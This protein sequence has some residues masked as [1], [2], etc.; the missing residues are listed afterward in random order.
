MNTSKK[1][2]C[3]M[4]Y[5]KYK[6]GDNFLINRLKIMFQFIVI[7]VLLTS[8]NNS[9]GKI[10]TYRQITDNDI[11]D[12]SVSIDNGQ[13]AWRG[14]GENGK[15]AIFFMDLNEGVKENLTA[16]K[17]YGY[18]G[19][20]QISNGQ[21]TWRRYDGDNNK[22]SILLWDGQD[23]HIVSEYDCGDFPYQGYPP[24]YG[25][26]EP[27]L[28]NGQIAYAAWDGNDYEIFY[29]NGTEIIQITDNLTNDYEAQLWNGTISYTGYKDESAP[30]DIFYWDG[31]EIQNISDKAG[32][33]EDSHLRESKIVH[34]AYGLS[35]EYGTDIYIWDGSQDRC[36][37]PVIGY[38]YE[39][40]IF[41]SLICWTG[42][43]YGK[44][45]G[46]CVGWVWD[47][48]KLHN[49]ME[50][51]Y[52]VSFPR[53][54]GSM[55]AF[56]AHDGND[57][58][59]F[60]AEY[61]T[62]TYKPVTPAG[63]TLNILLENELAYVANGE[64]DLK[65]V[66][67]SDEGNPV[68]V[69]GLYIPDA[70]SGFEVQKRG[71]Y[72][73]LANRCGGVKIIDV[74]DGTNPILVSTVETPDMATHITL[75]GNYLYIG[76]RLG[77]LRILD[78]TIPE[79]VNEVGNLDL[80]GTTYGIA[81]KDNFAYV[82]NDYDG[83]Q[84]VDISDP[85]SPG[86]V[87][88]YDLSGITVWDIKIHDDYA[89]L[90][91]PGYG[92]KVLDISD[93]YDLREIGEC[94]LPDGSRPDHFLPPLDISFVDHYAFV[95]HG[96]DGALVLDISNP[97]YPRIVERIDT[98]GYAWGMSIRG[99]YL[100]VADGSE[101]FQIINISDYMQ[102]LYEDAEDGR[103][104]G[105]DIYD[106]SPDGAQVTN[107]F[108]ED[109][110][111]RVIHLNGSGHLNGYRLRSDDGSEWHN[112]SQ[113]VIEWSMKYSEFFTVY[114]DIETTA[115]QR[116]MVYKPVDFDDLGDGGYV[117]HGLGSDTIDGQWHTFVHD[118]Q[119]DIEEA[120]PGVTIL[121][122]NGF[123]IRGSG[124]VDDIG[125]MDTMLINQD[126]DS[127]G[128]TDFNETNIYGTDP[129]K[130]DT[131]EDGIID[132]DELS[133]WGLNWD[134]DYDGDNL[135]NLLDP[136]ADND[137]FLDGEEIAAGSDP[138]DPESSPLSLVVYEDAEDSSIIGWDVYD[139]DPPGALISNVYDEN[140][141]SR[142]IEFSGSGVTNGY[143]LRDQNGAPWH[144]T[145]QFVIE[146]SMKFDQNTNIYVDVE[147]TSGH[148]Y[149]LYTPVDYD[150]LGT[151]YTV[152][153]GLGVDAKN[154][155]WHTYRRDLQ[156]DLEEGQPGVSILEV[157]GFLIRGSGSVDDIGLMDTMLINQDTDSDGI[158]DFNETNIYGTD[159]NKAD[160][161]E[162]G[163]IDGD[164]LS[165]WG[166]NW[167][168]DYDGDNLINLL[169]P[170]A[171][172]DGFLDGEEI[173]AGSDPA[174]PESSPLSLVVYEDAEDSSIIGW[175]VY[176]D[177][178][179]GA[180]ISN[181]YDEN[182]QSRVIEFSGS[183]VTNGYRLRDQNGAPWH[184]TRQFVI[185]WSMKFDQNTNIYVD[186]ETT[187]GHRYLLYTPVD[188]DGLGTG[189]TV[190]H[191]LGVD[192]KNGLWHTYR[193]DL[194]ADLEEG[195]P[196][197]SILEVNGFLIRGSGSLDDIILKEQY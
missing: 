11:K 121:E 147:T 122:V 27:S 176:D 105:W 93:P 173:A 189:Y 119:T 85:E 36:L 75:D 109:R 76:D 181:V 71:N 44:P 186:V 37:I 28:H 144:N 182:R 19:T 107:G 188:Y 125:L 187:S 96:N 126:T 190:H 7:V 195:Q 192:A 120:Q 66:D 145:R 50:S 23:I 45:K 1:E 172:N 106:N 193:R 83:I 39:P 153:H 29:W 84:V 79:S 116:Y 26:L 151:G 157:N 49:V 141:Q 60:I 47:G 179:P 92:I 87:Q 59:I 10:W 133:Y 131:D 136:D 130:A 123:Y 56:T 12:S 54:D 117:Y 42:W 22:D 9:Y 162:D 43:P 100:Y 170:D 13:I 86:M 41:E 163:I 74:T 104:S 111:S 80:E 5:E 160:T 35:G 103:I 4:F 78:V 118:L 196:G 102:T 15:L 25:S 72:I 155:L 69:G 156:A 17:V 61:I 90:V 95:G 65:I 158:T 33:C 175:D 113:F 40:E 161:D 2:D 128:I 135:I 55:I 168:E 51:P 58:E 143:R 167:D 94:V 148:R 18:F 52:N 194:Q 73:F 124:S 171:D 132:G 185:E 164:E 68:E 88:R 166:L 134:E 154:G 127:D 8:Y 180:L 138:A 64:G 165:Y 63:E 32:T 34:S 30:S 137:G 191:G 31:T 53:A 112:S 62:G 197:V 89:Y 57:D 139:D 108:D 48:Y 110:Q 98:P 169:D 82:A 177:D 46:P 99:K 97:Y 129:N 21:V 77:G 150:G 24:S 142:V 3:K 140:R 146:W 184:N 101:G 20:P 81:I 178:P 114:V 159:P 16:D 38:D 91:C 67:I 174:D 6:N 14:Y 149:L 115:G 183:G 152:H 70:C